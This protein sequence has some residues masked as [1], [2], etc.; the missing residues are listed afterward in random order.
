MVSEVVALDEI[1]WQ[2][3]SKRARQFVSLDG[4]PAF[5]KVNWKP[6]LKFAESMEHS[7][8]QYADDVALISCDIEVHKS[9]LQ[10][11]D[12]KASDLDLTFK[13]PKCASFLFDGSKVM[14]QGLPLSKGSTRP[15]T[16]GHT[17]FLGKLIDV[18]LGATKKA[19]SKNM[20][21]RLTNLLTAT[22]S[23][24][25]RGEYKL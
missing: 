21:C 15:I 18:S 5:T 11:I 4:K 19:A 14:P 10:M 20:V 23:L 1:E 6:S 12:Q 2:P 13:P 16:E 7:L 8:K 25:I 17:K 24:P 9:V 3:C 22:D